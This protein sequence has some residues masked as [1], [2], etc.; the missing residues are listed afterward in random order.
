MD[1][2]TLT[3]AGRRPYRSALASRDFRRLFTAIA[4]WETGAWSYT[5]V[6]TAY[7][8]TQNG[9]ATAVAWLATSRWITGFLIAPYAGV[10]ADRFD[11]RRL[12]VTCASLSSVAMLAMAGVVALGLPLWMLVALSI[13]NAVLESPNRPAS[14]AMVP[15]IVGDRDLP[16]ANA[17]MNV[18]ENAVVAVGPALGGLLLLVADPVAGV[19]LNACTYAVAAL[20]IG[21]L[22]LRSRGAAGAG[23]GAL[24]QVAEGVGALLGSRVAAGAA[25]AT[26]L[27]SGIYGATVVVLVPLAHDIGIGEGG[28]GWLLTAAA[29]GSIAGAP[30]ASRLS[31]LP[32]LEIVVA[33][34]IVA[35]AIPFAFAA[36]TDDLLVLALL[37]AFSGAAMTVVDVI[38][39]TLV[40]RS[41]P[42]GVLGRALATF[43]AFTLAGIAAS[44]VAAGLVLD[45][46]GIETTLVAIAVA[47]SL[48]AVVCLPL[49]RGARVRDGQTEQ[50][51]ELLERLDLFRGVATPALETLAGRAERV[52]ASSGT[53]LVREGEPAGDLWLLESG[54]L[55]AH[56]RDQRF[57]KVVAPGYVGEI[58]LLHTRPRTATVVV[59]EPA[60]LLRVPGVDFLRALGTGEP[61]DSLVRLA[62][63]RVRRTR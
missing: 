27:C 30:L 48:L 12:M 4:V 35:E 63:E 22:S 62:D 18:L 60:V 37:M 33:T 21:S 51:V 42:D 39:L 56:S 43:D 3:A 7:V 46:A 26:A 25:I 1:T 55:A 53:V 16:A 20:L 61:S 59:D 32:R 2:A 19:L 13:T 38:A 45:A 36:M 10:L 34:A 5:I 50:R 41:V 15:E 6:L 54:T 17:M 9:S 47:F 29:L 28:Y 44:G 58:G 11:R 49:L 40:Q 52:E 31:G 23:E 57:P 14:G 24:R 8:F